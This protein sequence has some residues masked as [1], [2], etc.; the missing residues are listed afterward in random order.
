MESPTFNTINTIINMQDKS[1]NLISDNNNNNNNNNNNSNINNNNNHINLQNYLIDNPNQ[2]QQHNLNN[3]YHQTLKQLHENFIQLQHPIHDHQ[4]VSVQFPTPPYLNMDSNNNHYHQSNELNFNMLQLHTSKWL[5][6]VPNKNC[7]YFID[8]KCYDNEIILFSQHL[9]EHYQLKKYHEVI[10]LKKQTFQ[11]LQNSRYIHCRPTVVEYM[12]DLANSISVTR[13][14]LESA[15]S[16]YDRY[17]DHLDDIPKSRLQ[18]V[19]ITSFYIACKLHES[20]PKVPS[21]SDL[22]LSTKFSY[23][24]VMITDMEL[25][26]LKTLNWDANSISPSNFV[27]YLV[28]V[29][30]E[31]I[32]IIYNH[33]LQPSQDPTQLE[34][35]FQKK[36]NIFLDKS[37]K[38]PFS[39]KVHPSIIAS[40]CIAATRSQLNL[41]PIWKPSLIF[42]S[43]YHFQEISEY[44]HNLL[45]NYPIQQLSP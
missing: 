14:T 26:I 42:L 35:Q 44:Y 40:A 38:C 17:L 13:T 23:S 33:Q 30:L 3:I 32:D 7:I 28:L 27:D 43:G 4:N 29:G 1:I 2:I 5:N 11:S 34:K 36:L 41:F 12:C 15:V 21:P 25:N 39:R 37:L 18:L 8:Q 16:I 19:A 6:R 20:E 24:E 9:Y 45:S 10:S 22:N 31:P